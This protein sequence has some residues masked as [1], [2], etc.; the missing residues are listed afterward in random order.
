MWRYGN[1]VTKTCNSTLYVLTGSFSSTV[2]LFPSPSVAV[3]VFPLGWTF[4]NRKQAFSVTDIESMFLVKSCN[5]NLSLCQTNL[6]FPTRPTKQTGRL[7]C[8]E[9]IEQFILGFGTSSMPAILAA[10]CYG[11]ADFLIMATARAK[12][13]VLSFG[14]NCSPRWRSV[15]I[16]GWKHSNRG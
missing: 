15:D 3:N 8:C 16:S 9:S 5:L 2:A 11:V 13:D 6:T 4:R 14:S 10:C 12:S 1:A 7:I